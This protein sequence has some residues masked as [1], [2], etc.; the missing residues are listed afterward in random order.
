MNSEALLSAQSL[1][2]QFPL[3]FRNG[4]RVAGVGFW[5]TSCKKALPLSEVR[6]HLGRIVERVVDIT[7]AARCACGEVNQYRIRL[8]DD[9]TC[10]YIKDGRWVKESSGNDGKLGILGRIRIRLMFLW[11]RWRCY[12]LSRTLKTMQ[13]DFRNKCGLKPDL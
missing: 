1:D 13:R 9:A 7:A 11:I 10:S 3:E 4:H 2:G 5:C 12:L 6:G 8:H